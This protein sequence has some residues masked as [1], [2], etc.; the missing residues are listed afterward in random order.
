MSAPQRR[1]AAVSGASGY[2]GGVIARRL[3][4]D[5]WHVVALTRTPTP[6]AD[7][8]RPW[9]LGS[10]AAPPLAGVDLLVHAAYDFAPTDW[11]DIE[12][13]NVGG[14]RTLFD[15]ALEDDVQRLIHLSSLAAFPGARSRYGTAK[16][17]TEAAAVARGGVVVRPGLVYG[18]GAGA[19]FAGL[20]RM[21]ARLPV[22]P[23]IVGDGSPMLLA[24]EQDVGELVAAIAAGREEETGRP[25][26]AANPEPVTLRGLL[27]SMAQARGRSPRFV[28]VPWRAVFQALRSLERLGLHPP[29][30]SDSALSLATADTHPFAAAS[31]PATVAFR[32]FR[33]ALS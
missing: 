28:P 17:L 19:M 20:E 22:I 30:R 33:P 21:A 6:N 11:M 25:L 27:S 13:I 7:E 8:H 31:A 12:R 10:V 23:L 3:R 9:D 4:A 2:V 24:H 29:F 5:G 14:A 32:P 16:L 1:T 26:V 15:A 18:P